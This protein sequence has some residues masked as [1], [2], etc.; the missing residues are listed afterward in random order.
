MRMTAPPCE[1]CQLKGN[2]FA[3]YYCTF[4]EHSAFGCK[5]EKCTYHTSVG[6][7]IYLEGRCGAAT[8]KDD[9]E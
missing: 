7:V 8:K 5:T 2:E 9:S 3:C 1:F 6:C 4:G